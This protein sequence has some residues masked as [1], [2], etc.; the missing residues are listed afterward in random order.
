M[1]SF[2]VKK[3]EKKRERVRERKITWNRLETCWQNDNWF[4]GIHFRLFL[5]DIRM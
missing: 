4:N 3:K 1:V 5:E 2:S